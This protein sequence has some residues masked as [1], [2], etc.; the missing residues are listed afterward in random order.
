MVL[1]ILFVEDDPEDA[2]MISEGFSRLG[3]TQFYFCNDPVTAFD[4]LETL[5]DE[6]LP[7]LIVCDY[8]MGEM[9]GMEL[10]QRLKFHP[11][12]EHIPVYIYTGT[13]TEELKNVLLASGAVE[14]VQ[15]QYDLEMLG[16]QLVR[17]I[18]LA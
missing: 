3:F 15:K 13:M 6:E 7:T 12:Y 17:F 16:Y 5:Q 2:E 4:H 8:F 18:E 11:R 14:V 10:L 9:T 1:K